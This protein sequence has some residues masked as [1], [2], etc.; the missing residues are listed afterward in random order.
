[1]ADAL[2]IIT[3]AFRSPPTPIKNSYEMKSSRI[4]NAW[5]AASI[6]LAL[7]AVAVAMIATVRVFPGGF[8]TQAVWGI[9]LLPGQ[10]PA[11]MLSGLFNG[12]SRR[13]EVI[14]FW[15][16]ATFFTWIWYSLVGYCIVKAL[17]HVP[18]SW[19]GF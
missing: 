8:E 7:S 1:V 2:L 19:D 3:I 17:R 4:P 16:L 13:T 15:A 11:S 10:L 6:G 5:L 9:V 18:K 12:L 14:V